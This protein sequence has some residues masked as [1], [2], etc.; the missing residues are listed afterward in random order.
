LTR[1]LPEW[2]RDSKAGA[3]AQPSN[4][5]DLAIMCAD[6][7]PADGQAQAMARRCRVAERLMPV[8]RLE[9]TLAVVVGHAWALVVDA[10]LQ[11]A[12]NRA[13][14]NVDRRPRR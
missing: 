14:R 7:G 2:Q 1:L 13:R 9:D 10:Q 8:E 5:P 12:A 4:R 11:H 6:D 3:T